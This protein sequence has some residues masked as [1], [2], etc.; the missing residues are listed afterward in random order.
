M[1]T[2][3]MPLDAMSEADGGIE[4]FR[5]A[6]ASEVAALLRRLQD[7]NV[8]LNLVAP[9]GGPTTP[10]CGRPMPRGVVSFAA[11]ARDPQLQ[12]LLEGDEAVAVGYLENI[13]V[14]F[15]VEQLV[16]V[17]G[18]QACALN[19]TYPRQMFRFQRRASYRVR[20]VLRETPVARLRHPMIPD[21]HLALRVL[22]VSVTGCA[23]LL[24]EDVPALAP[25]VQINR[26]E[27][28]LD[29]NTCFE[30]SLRLHH[31]T[32]IQPDS[33]GVRLG[34]EMLRLGQEA[35]RAAA[36]RRPDAEAPAVQRAGDSTPAP[37]GRFTPAFTP[38][39][40]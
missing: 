6:T 22:D 33:R 13:K 8:L 23:L 9:H 1:T 32:A 7:A 2:Q 30:C 24:P 16:M 18:A 35:Q 36:L 15:D 4:D 39:C 19:A 21:M 3:A 12:A 40:S 29:H 28:E 5:V 10:R 20:P 17:H 31:V 38:A 11:D 14:Q 26:V 34:C 37:A 27:I 25:G